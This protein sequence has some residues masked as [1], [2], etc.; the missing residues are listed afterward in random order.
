MDLVVLDIML[1]KVSGLM[2]L[3]EIRQKSLV[4]VLMLTAVEDEYTQVKSF[5]EQA[6]DYITK[7]F[8]MILLGRR[9]TALLRRSGKGAASNV[10]TFGDVTVNFS[11]YTAKD[12]SSRRIDITP[13]EI[14]LLRLLVEHQGLV[15]FIV[16]TAHL[17]IYLFTKPEWLLISVSPYEDMPFNTSL[18]VADYVTQAVL[19][20]LPLS[21]ICCVVIS[22]ACSFVYSRRIT[23]PIKQIGTVTEQ[24]AQ[25]KRDAACRISSKDEIG[26]LAENINHLYQSLL[27]AMES[28]EIEKQR[29]SE[30]ER[31]K[32][33][34]LRAASHELK[35][36]ITA[37]NAT[38]EN[39]GITTLTCRSAGK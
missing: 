9:I 37:L 1:P 35:T 28:L 19:K 5:D 22:I 27:S 4:P 25:M 20:A 32:A 13:K 36:P 16:G 8:S 34:F 33:D 17:L 7:P 31:S 11:G 18:N 29:V 15:L 30:S 3:H 39:T 21:L 10:M 2:V 14:D 26:I 24:M 6:D 12:S 38:L 23:V